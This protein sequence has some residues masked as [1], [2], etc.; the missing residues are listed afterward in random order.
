MTS[1]PLVGH[2]TCALPLL[3]GSS[4]RPLHRAAGVGPRAAYRVTPLTTTSATC[5]ALPT[6][7]KRGW[8][9]IPTF[10][11]SFEPSDDLFWLGRMLSVQGPSFEN[12]LYG[13]GHV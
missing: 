4:P 3:K 8:V 12:A 6:P 2:L 7:F 13:L 5:G 10:G 1:D 9:P 11:D